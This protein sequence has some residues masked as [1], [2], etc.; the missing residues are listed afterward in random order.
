MEIKFRL[1]EL[2]SAKIFDNVKKNK[3]DVMTRVEAIPGDITKPSFAI[4]EDDQRYKDQDKSLCLRLPNSRKL[5]EEVSIVFHSAATVRFDEDLTKS[6]DL[7]VVAVFT[8]MD[9]CR[10]ME[11]LEVNFP[12]HL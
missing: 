4:S 3:P 6:V 9:I 7:N 8:I 5:T 2:M 11:K 12:I 10:K 1:Q